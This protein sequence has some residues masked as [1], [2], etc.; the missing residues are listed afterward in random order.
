MSEESTI[1][2]AE[3][4]AL[5]SKADL[6]GISYHPSIKAEKLHTKIQE[7]LADKV[8]P[9]ADKVAPEASQVKEAN[10]Q[11]EVKKDQ[12]T[13][14]RVRV[15]SMNPQHATHDG[16]MI[17]TGNKLTGSIRKFVKY[18]EPWHV[19]MI[20]LEQLKNAKFQQHYDTKGKN[21][22]T[23]QRSKMVPT[24]AIEYLD[25]LTPKELKELARVQAMESGSTDA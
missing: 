10:S 13:L 18:N 12:L 14:H 4:D 8:D 7:A 5:K 24:Y 20:I 9:D 23:I 3:L 11:A 1:E 25:A 17:T 6:L 16:T 19:P 2:Q 21:N 15:T 22:R